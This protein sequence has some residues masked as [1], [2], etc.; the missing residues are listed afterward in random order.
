MNQF[1]IEWNW[2]RI[3][4]GGLALFFILIL[5][6]GFPD[7]S[8]PW[9]DEG[10]HLNLA[11]N[12]AEQGVLNLRI[13]PEEF[14]R[15]KPLLISTNYPLLAP[16]A[17]SFKLFGV[18]LEQGKVVSY[19]FLSIFIIL[20]YWLVRKNYG[21]NNALLTLA[22]LIT[23]LPL[24]GNGKSVLGEI[25]G[26]VYLLAGLLI[27]ERRGIGSIF[28]VGLLF[29]LAAATKSSYLIILV[30]LAF[31]ELWRGFKDK[32]FDFQ[33]WLILGSGLSIPLL[34]WIFTLLPNQ[35]SLDFWFSVWRLYSNPY[36]V[37]NTVLLNIR[38]FFTESTPLYFL[39]FLGVILIGNILKKFR[40]SVTE[41]TLITFIFLNLV[42]YLN[43]VGWY[44]YFFPAHILTIILFP[45][46]LAS[47][48]TVFSNIYLKQYGIWAI[49]GVLTVIQIGVLWSNW[50]NSIYYSSIPRQF[51]ERAN[52]II[53]DQMVLVVDN[54]EITFFLKSSRVYMHI[55]PNPHII[56]G[57]D[58][59]QKT[60][61]SYIISSPWMENY[62]LSRYTELARRYHLEYS[63]GNY[64]LY[65]LSSYVGRSN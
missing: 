55:R 14:V 48:T 52:Q 16:V 31:G 13:G 4:V 21:K 41:V 20:A 35:W 43:T 18:G 8:A 24:Y 2:H 27:L 11:K 58:L 17:L 59:L 9:F 64:N 61:P 60:V 40:L 37:Q 51:A 34:I 46:A 29:G 39:L 12:W 3:A 10:I 49:V 19:I 42:F 33:R 26:L 62:Y 53:G 30:A 38:R 56:F 7:S 1:F 5:F 44:R 57:K 45:Q 36:N 28:S 50:G 25:P 65:S 47:V 54:P 15:E 22:L 32:K 63:L 23:F 6:W